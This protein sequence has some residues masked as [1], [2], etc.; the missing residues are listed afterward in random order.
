MLLAASTKLRWSP[1]PPLTL[2]VARDGALDD[3]DTWLLMFSID[4]RPVPGGI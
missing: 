3:A 1:P 4:D 2:L